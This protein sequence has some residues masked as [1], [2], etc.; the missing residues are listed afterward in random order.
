MKI[1]SQSNAK[2]ELRGFSDNGNSDVSKGICLPLV[3][4]FGL[5]E[6]A[7]HRFH[8]NRDLVYKSI[9]VEKN[10]QLDR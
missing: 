3:I 4:D 8:A 1:I 6:I 9:D 10:I 7:F 5:K 2:I